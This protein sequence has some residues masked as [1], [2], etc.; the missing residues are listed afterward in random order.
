MDHKTRLERHELKYGPHFNEACAECAVAKMVNE[1]GSHGAH[2]NIEETTA[3]AQQYGIDLKT[4]HFN[5]YDWYVA[6]NMIRSDYYKAIIA[7]T[8]NDN[9]KYFVEF[10][11]AWLKDKDI[12][13]GKMWYYYKY[14]MCDYF[15]EED[16]EDEEYEEYYYPKHKRSY[17]YD[18]DEEYTPRVERSRNRRII[19]RY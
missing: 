11:K 4:D 6:L 12:D 1:D 13:T 8:N 18:E 10:A 5:K 9:A 2:W 7:I 3:L 19:S 16:E 14:V 17:Y 15:R